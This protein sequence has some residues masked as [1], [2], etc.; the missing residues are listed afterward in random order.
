MISQLEARET[1]SLEEA[2]TDVDRGVQRLPEGWLVGWDC[3][4]GGPP[5][6]PVLVE[7]VVLNPAFGVALLGSAKWVEGADEVFRQRLV[8]ARFG[9]IFGGHLPILSGTIESLD[10]PRL[11]PILVDAF[12]RV[13][14]LDLAGGDAW[15][16]TVTRLVVPQSRCWTD[17]LQ[18]LP[19]LIG[20]SRGTQAEADRSTWRSE[21]ATVVPLRRV[22]EPQPR[23][24]EA[25]QSLPLPYPAHIT[26]RRWPW[27]LCALASAVAMVLSLEVPSTG[28]P[29]QGV[30][31]A[32]ADAAVLPLAAIAA[33]GPSPGSDPAKAPGVDAAL[34]HAAAT[35][36]QA[37]PAAAEPAPVVP[38]IAAPRAGAAPPRVPK[39][40]RTEPGKVV[41]A[42][43]AKVKTAPAA[44]PASAVRLVAVKRPHTKGSTR[45]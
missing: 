11:V 25:E 31:S 36:P 26:P 43:V 24:A 33:A 12:G 16:S 44:K 34:L 7:L 45:S 4:I 22:T 3:D 15:V 8:E 5:G 10:L 29:A 28:D 42:N 6:H 37:T 23:E 38:L 39:M 18:G 21:P 27:A 32:I 41:Q 40:P 35:P 1:V 19:P 17:N 20:N 9:A 14:P 2:T 30:P 13:Q